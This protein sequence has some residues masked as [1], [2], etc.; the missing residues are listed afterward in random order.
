M[1]PWPLTLPCPALD[2]GTWGGPSASL[3]V[4]SEQ[5]PLWEVDWSTNV[6]SSQG[7]TSGDGSSGLL[8]VTV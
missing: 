1:L 5:S 4:F 8:G 6:S 7:N 2:H 3:Y